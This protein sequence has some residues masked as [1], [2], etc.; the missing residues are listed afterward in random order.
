M[1]DY[2]DVFMEFSQMFITETFL[3]VCHCIITIIQFINN[4]LS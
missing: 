2:L 4:Y 3:F 1:S